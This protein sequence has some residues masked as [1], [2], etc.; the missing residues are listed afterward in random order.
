MRHKKWE[1][2]VE[3]DGRTGGVSQKEKRKHI[4]K[5]TLN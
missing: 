4:P 1:E 2:T 3:K 5:E